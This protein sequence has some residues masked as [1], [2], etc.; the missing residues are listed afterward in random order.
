MEHKIYC[1]DCID[2]IWL[3]EKY[4][5]KLVLWEH[6]CPSYAGLPYTY[7]H[8]NKLKNVGN[9][10]DGAWWNRALGFMPSISCPS[11][12]N[13]STFNGQ[14]WQNVDIPIS[15]PFPCVRQSVLLHRMFAT[16]HSFTSCWAWWGRNS[17]VLAL[18][19]AATNLPFT[20][21]CHQLKGCIN[22][23]GPCTRVLVTVVYTLSVAH[24]TT[25]VEC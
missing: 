15:N 18:A 20:Q 21:Q 22:N 25:Y 24:G 11:M 7:W 8:Q 5:N 10:I 9:S 16:R 23:R 14:F 19:D 12:F 3:L 2:T 17:H 1:I 4:C 13:S 6:H